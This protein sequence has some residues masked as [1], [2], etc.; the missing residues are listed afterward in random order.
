[1]IGQNGSRELIDDVSHA[2][3]ERDLKTIAPLSFLRSDWLLPMVAILTTIIVFKTMNNK[4]II[5]RFGL[6]DILNTVKTR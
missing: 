4:A 3:E 2:N 6:C 5:I 1:M